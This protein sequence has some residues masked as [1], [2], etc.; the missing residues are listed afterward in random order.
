VCPSVLQPKRESQK[1]LCQV[2]DNNNQCGRNERVPRLRHAAAPEGLPLR[3]LDR[4][5]VLVRA[6]LPHGLAGPPRALGL[7]GGHAARRD[8]VGRQGSHRRRWIRQVQGQ[9]AGQ[10]FLLFECSTAILNLSCRFTFI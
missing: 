3:R 5:V 7:A 8:R 6:Q 2:R 10:Y 1:K 4:A 9:Q